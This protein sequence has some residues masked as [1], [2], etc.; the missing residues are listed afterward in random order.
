MY[1]KLLN[2]FIFMVN[3][4]I[5]VLEHVLFNL[6]RSLNYTRTTLLILL[7]PFNWISLLQK[8]SVSY[9]ECELDTSSFIQVITV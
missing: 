7:N 6:F 4:F 9:R 8:L 2:L 1:K 3:S 5:F